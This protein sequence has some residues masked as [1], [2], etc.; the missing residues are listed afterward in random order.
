MKIGDKIVVFTDIHF[1]LKN[2]ERRHNEE[3]LAFIR[4]MIEE[5]KEFGAETSIFSGDWHHM[6]SSIQTSTLSHS[7]I[8]FQLL[9]EAFKDHYQII[10]N[11]DLFYKDK[12]EIHSVE[13][14]SNFSNIHIIN[15]ITKVGDVVLSPWLVGT[16]HKKIVKMTNP[17]I[18]G[19]FELPHFLMNALV[20]MPDV[21]HIRQDDFVGTNQTVFSGH[22]HKRQVQRNT[23]GN[24]II[25][26]GNC[27]PHNFSDA[28]DD[29]RGIMLLE[30]GKKPIYKKWP[31]APKYR[32]LNLSQLIDNPSAH[33]DSKTTA[34]VTIDLD[35]SYEEANFI[36]ETMAQEYHVRELKLIPNQ[37]HIANV[38]ETDGMKFETVE[39][40][41]V[42]QLG[43]I[44]S[45]TLD[46]ELLINI[47]KNI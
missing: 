34:K 32:V 37:S 10:G 22:F 21:G 15:E 16:E 29:D 46:K 4:W 30:L 12:R 9:S 44:E 1:G 33:I 26:M 31:D 39:Q 11:H 6:R 3:C 17:Y 18:F 45:A 8:G 28:G 20:A 23:H 13:F 43:A 19:H 14:A 38:I 47:Y 42:E 36:K 41:V 2:N 7:N 40:I 27:F 24:E 35:I 5:A 25:Y